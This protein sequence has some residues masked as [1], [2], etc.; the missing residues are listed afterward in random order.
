MEVRMYTLGATLEL[1]VITHMFHLA[2]GIAYA[3]K[4]LQ[5]SKRKYQVYIPVSND[6][7]Y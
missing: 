2:I 5:A 3:G 7:L 6:Q 1:F 4:V